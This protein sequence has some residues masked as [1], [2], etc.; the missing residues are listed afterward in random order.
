MS[1]PY[2]LSDVNVV[3]IKIT[4]TRGRTVDLLSQMIQISIFEDLSQPTLYCEISMADALNLVKFLPI[5]G[6]EDLEITFFTPGNNKMT[7]YNFVVYS[8]EG[9]GVTNN[10]KVSVYTIKCVSKEHFI[11]S[12]V[13]VEKSWRGLVSDAVNDIM[14]GYIGTDKQVNIEQTKGILPIALPSMSPFRAVDY[15]R[16]KAVNYKPTGGAY[17]FFENQDGFHFVSLEKLLEEGAS[18]IGNKVFVHATDTQTDNKRE[19]RAWRNIVRYEH[20]SKHDSVSKLMKGM[21]NNNVKTWDIFTK[22]V[23]DTNF[24]YQQKEGMILNAAGDEMARTPNS[25]RFVSEYGSDI[26]VK[27]FM[28]LDSSKGKDYLPDYHG[29]K[30]AYGVLFNQNITRCLIRGDNNIK[31]GDVVTLKLPDTTGLTDTVDEDGM[32]SGNFLITRLR[33]IIYFNKDNI[34]HDIAMDCNKIGVNA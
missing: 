19:Q 2:I 22:K 28:P 14:Y 26:S 9:T 23:Q 13:N 34:K 6:E 7:T 3:D 8:V 31:A 20:I 25:S 4:S 17:V 27:Y 24:V 10:N 18:R 12:V 30:S 1:D 21:Y 29:S 33:H 11:N 32:Y 5:I 16:Q 15:L